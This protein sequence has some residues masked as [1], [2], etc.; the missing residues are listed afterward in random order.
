MRLLD[1]LFRRGAPPPL[2]DQGGS[3]SL[4]SDTTVDERFVITRLLGVGGTSSVYAARQLSMEREV[5]PKILHPDLK[6]SGNAQ[7]RIL[8]DVG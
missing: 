5:A 7:T 2:P 4:P 3:P 1:R 8:P 6:S